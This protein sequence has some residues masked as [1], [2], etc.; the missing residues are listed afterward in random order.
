MLSDLKTRSKE[1]ENIKLSTKTFFDPN[2][3]K[4]NYISNSHLLNILLVEDN[5]SDEILTRIA[6]EAT[7]MINNV[8]SV[9]DGSKAVNYLHRSQEN[10]FDITPDIILLDL[11]LPEKDGF[12]VLAE[13]N[14]DNNYNDIPIVILTGFNYYDYIT[15]AYPNLNIMSYVTKPCT[16]SKFE[17]IFKEV[18]QNMKK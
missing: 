15:N 5:K 13:L 2:I 12:E 6:L 11:G 10:R 1:K 18:V 16:A 7:K 17:T 14:E 9:S 4:N 8:L 3:Y